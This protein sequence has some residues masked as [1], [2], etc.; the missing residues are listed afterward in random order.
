MGFVRICGAR[1]VGASRRRRGGTPLKVVGSQSLSILWLTFDFF[2]EVT[3]RNRGPRLRVERA[4]STHFPSDSL[5]RYRSPVSVWPVR[6]TCRAVWHPFIDDPASRGLLTRTCSWCSADYYCSL[7]CCEWPVQFFMY[8]L[9][10][11]C[12]GS[13]RSVW[14][15]V[16]VGFAG[17]VC[18][19]SS[20][21]TTI[22]PV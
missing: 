12:H 7:R 10:P 21:P 20:L 1:E 17:M 3:G 8:R 9:G 2:R 4:D 16:S 6:R 13:L 15:L 5:R 22:I 11:L 19:A 18:D 14:L